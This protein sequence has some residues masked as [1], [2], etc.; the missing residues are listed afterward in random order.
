ML[1]PADALL[2]SLPRAELDAADTA[3][4]IHGQ[5]VRWN[6]QIGRWRAYG[7]GVF[8]GLCELDDAG[9]LAPRRLISGHQPQQNTCANA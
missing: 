1:A 6:G 5:S 2:D 8:L 4:L 3:R 9:W 7:G